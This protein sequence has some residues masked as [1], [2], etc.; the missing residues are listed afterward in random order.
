MRETGD[1]IRVLEI[2]ADSLDLETD[3]RL[4]VKK[5]QSMT[6]RRGFRPGQV[7]QKMIRRIYANEIENI[8]V[9]NL[10]QEV[11]EDLVIR[12]DEH[13]VIGQPREI[14]RQYKLDED[15]HVQIEFYVAPKIE[16][17][18][19]SG[20]VLEVPVAGVTDHLIQFF[21]QVQLI[22]HLPLRPLNPNEK[23]GEPSLGMFDRITYEFENIDRQTGQVLIGVGDTKKQQIFDYFFA[24]KKN[25]EYLDFG[26]IFKEHSVGDVFF[27][28]NDGP[29][30]ELIQ[31]GLEDSKVRIKIL[32]A[33]RYDWPEM[34]DKWA[35]LISDNSVDSHEDLN[36]WAKEFLESS[37]RYQNRSLLETNLKKRLCELH[38]F[39]IPTEFL[40]QLDEHNL[41]DSFEGTSNFDQLVELLQEEFRWSILFT[42]IRKKYDYELSENPIAS[43]SLDASDEYEES[44]DQGILS[45]LVKQFEIKNIPLTELETICI[46]AKEN[47]NSYP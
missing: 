35:K 25:K 13:D 14:S 46:V 15:L 2:K 43:E 24:L 5:Q 39:S 19:L 18:D 3:V 41:L 37:F 12:N 44:L 6:T 34:N 36:K 11:F 20:Q 38:S 17:K 1:M 42:L 21:I 16:L 4:A 9:Q 28:D 7:P 33:E 26:D 29:H 32:E 8:V 30:S 22:P 31:S 10:V 47:E 23:I 45:E 27:I 40:K